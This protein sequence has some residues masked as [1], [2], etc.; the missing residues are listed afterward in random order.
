VWDVGACAQAVAVFRAMARR[1]ARGATT[2]ECLFTMADVLRARAFTLG[3]AWRAG[4][5]ERLPCLPRL[6]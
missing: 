5:L 1:A 2:G 6:P 4:A 3:P